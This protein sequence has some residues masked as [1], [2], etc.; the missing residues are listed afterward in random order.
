MPVC[1]YMPEY[2]S[3]TPLPPPVVGI[4]PTVNLRL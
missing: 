1:L 2:L 4:F 3:E